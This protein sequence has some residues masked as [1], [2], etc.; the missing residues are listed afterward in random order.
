MLARALITEPMLLVLDEPTHALD[1]RTA[2]ALWDLLFREHQ[3]GMTIL[4]AVSELPS[5][6]RFESCL[7]FTLP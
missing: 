7:K 6:A 3:R 4:A 2:A 5:D 1:Q